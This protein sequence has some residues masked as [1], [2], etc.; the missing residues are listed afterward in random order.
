MTDDALNFLFVNVS[1]VNT[2]QARR[3]G[4]QKQHVA[5]AQQVFRAVSIDDRA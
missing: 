3:T 1:P 2:N 4:R 5:A